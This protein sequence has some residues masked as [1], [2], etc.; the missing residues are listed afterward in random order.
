M[1]FKVNFQ[2]QEP[3]TT[4]VWWLHGK[5]QIS[6]LGFAVLGICMFLAW[7][8]KFL[9]TVFDIRTIFNNLHKLFFSICKNLFHKNLQVQA[10]SKKKLPQKRD[11]IFS[12]YGRNKNTKNQVQQKG[13]GSPVR[14]CTSIHHSADLWK[15]M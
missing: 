6:Y 5:L 11:A 13:K 1:T 14:Y 12:F 4:D 7:N 9:E 8:R 2:C 10:N 3:P 15:L